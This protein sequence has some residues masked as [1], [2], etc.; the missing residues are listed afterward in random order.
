MYIFS[1]EKNPLYKGSLRKLLV[2]ILYVKGLELFQS[3]P[4]DSFLFKKMLLEGKHGLGN[5]AK[6][7]KVQTSLATSMQFK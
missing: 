6:A 5:Q 7:F 1:K 3:K 4:V 2:V